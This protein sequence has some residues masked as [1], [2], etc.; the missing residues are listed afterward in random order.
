M[1]VK[2]RYAMHLLSTNRPSVDSKTRNVDP[3]PREGEG[4]EGSDRCWFLMSLFAQ[5]SAI[6]WLLGFLS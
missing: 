3:C 4:A 2:A 6:G 1:R 5:C